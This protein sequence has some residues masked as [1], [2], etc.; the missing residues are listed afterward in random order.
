MNY[1]EILFDGRFVDRNLFRGEPPSPEVDEA[2]ESLGV[3]CKYY[4]IT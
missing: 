4:L 3:R 2:W 1:H